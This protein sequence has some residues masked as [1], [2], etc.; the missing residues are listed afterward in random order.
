MSL[1]LKNFSC[2][3]RIQ[4]F[5]KFKGLSFSYLEENFPS[6]PSLQSEISSEDSIKLLRDIEYN[7]PFPIGFIGPIESIF[8]WSAMI[9]TSYSHLNQEILESIFDEI[10]EK[11]EDEYFVMGPTFSV[12][13]CVLMSD[14]KEIE[15][16]F[17]LPDLIKQYTLRVENFL[18]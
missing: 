16:N 17:V 4:N 3:G 13:D 15:K 14:L 6:I 1:L 7:T 9:L 18:K 11:V 5:L 2:W 8:Q 12:A 10:I